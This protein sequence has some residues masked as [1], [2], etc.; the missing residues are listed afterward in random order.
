M[1]F[2]SI[3]IASTLISCNISTAEI[4]RR[5]E[6]VYPKKVPDFHLPP[7]EI[8]ELFFFTGEIPESNEQMLERLKNTYVDMVPTNESEWFTFANNIDSILDIVPL[9]DQKVFN[10]FA[11]FL[12]HSL[13]Y[14][15]MLKDM[16]L[17]LVYETKNENLKKHWIDHA[18]Q[19][20]GTLRC[21]FNIYKIN[22]DEI[23]FCKNF[24]KLTKVELFCPCPYSFNKSMTWSNSEKVLSILKEIPACTKLELVGFNSDMLK[25]FIDGA[26]KSKSEVLKNLKKLK[27]VFD[28]RSGIR[29]INS[30]VGKF[31]FLVRSL[32][33]LSKITIENQDA[34]YYPDKNSK[35]DNLVKLIEELPTDRDIAIKLI[36][37][38]IESNERP[39]L[40]FVN[41]LKENQKFFNALKDTP[42][43]V[44]VSIV[45]N[46][47]SFNKFDAFSLKDKIEDPKLNIKIFGTRNGTERKIPNSIA[48]LDNLLKVEYFHIWFNTKFIEVKH[49]S[50]KDFPSS[51]DPFLKEWKCEWKCV[52]YTDEN[53]RTEICELLEFVKGFKT[54]NTCKYIRFRSNFLDLSDKDDMND[55][56]SVVN[57]PDKELVLH[58]SALLI[59]SEEFISFYKKMQGKRSFTLNVNSWLI[60]VRKG[61]MGAFILQIPK[62]YN[63]E[64]HEIRQKEEFLGKIKA[65]SER[66]CFKPDLSNKDVLYI[67]DGN[68]DDVLKVLKTIKNRFKKVF[69]AEDAFSIYQIKKLRTELRKGGTC[70]LEILTKEFL[71]KPGLKGQSITNESY[72]IRLFLWLKPIFRCYS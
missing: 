48:F 30:A 5:D 57:E 36:G 1:R 13:K 56:I 4:Q 34:L 24:S 6:N 40:E 10:K 2:S 15:N 54:F 53:P 64:F 52:E 50:V 65:L 20:L 71:L 18:V 49:T 72:L 47:Y 43:K 23:E 16:D 37:R 67:E 14:N 17:R 12:L 61:N 41:A 51:L 60:R 66:D 11:P 7:H 45:Y 19:K 25:D 44:K 63:M 39:R 69:I 9:W 28:A 33:N 58:A 29:Y 68:F 59:D 46:L 35:S 70:T 31:P 62:T 55:F 26:A 42:E 8:P 32:K 21:S 22:D 3:L 27:I 38:F